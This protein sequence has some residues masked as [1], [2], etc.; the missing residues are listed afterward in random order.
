M[1]R[2]SIN[3][4]RLIIC[5]AAIAL[6]ASRAP[7]AQIFIPAETGKAGQVVHIPVM[8]DQ[9]DNLAGIKLVMKYDKGILTF[10]KAARTKQTSSLM[11]IVN[12]KKPG[13]L[14]IVMAGAKGIKGKNFS[15]LSLA[16]EAK[17][18]LTS[19]HS[20]RIDIT[21]VQM[22]SDRLKDI[23]C[24]IEVNPIVILPE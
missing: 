1:F 8:I 12:D 3:R 10:K 11:H 4:I 21:Q 7:A 14:I 24:S 6:S 16:F 2:I 17:K 15:I 19:N 22:M 23:K 13:I 9:V 18:G 20:T 5:V